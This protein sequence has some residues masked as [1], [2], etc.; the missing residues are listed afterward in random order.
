MPGPEKLIQ[1]IKSLGLN[2]DLKEVSR[3]YEFAAKAH[4]GQKRM[5]GEDFIIHPL[6]TAVNLAEMKVDQASILAG[7]L[8]D[9]VEDTP[10]SVKE[11]EKHF[12]H[13]VAFLVDSV[14][15]LKKVRYY[16]S[17]NYLE[18]LRKMFVAMAKDIRVILIKFAD[19]LHNLQTL[20]YLPKDEQQRIAKETL[21]I[22]APIANR[23]RL[24]RI[25]GRLEDWAFRYANPEDFRW[26]NNLSMK[27]YSQREGN[28]K[29]TETEI[30]KI[31]EKE[32]IR[33]VSIHDRTKFLYS[34]FKKMEAKQVAV[35]KIY[36]LVA[37]RIIVS[38]VP[39]CY[40]ALGIIHQKYK[41]LKGRIKDYIAQP[42]PNGYQSLH[43]TV[44]GENGDILEV[45]IR[46]P[47]IHEEAEYGIAAHWHY[48]DVG[49]K[50]YWDKR[51]SWVK[52][53]AHLM[54]RLEDSK[55]LE[56]LKI[57]FFQRRIFVFTP[58]GDVIDLPDNATPVDFAYHI[59][60][61]IGNKT[62][63]A[64]VNDHLVSLD[65]KLQNGDVV[66][67]ITNKKQ[68]G[69]NANWLKF[70]RTSMARS[71]IKEYH[72]EKMTK[73]EKGITSPSA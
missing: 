5:S 13:E 59:H 22:Y 69:P 49:I 32:K 48:K 21:E 44:F 60:T 53:L 52:E 7:L 51:L 4:A 55:D 16:G 29:K 18:N 65:T 43:T 17:P 41:P 23:L 35:D 8:H 28:L 63:R 9:V 57:D 34:L 62:T 58:N 45:Q 10:T 64:K 11:I 14:S 24:G 19:R 50:E 2:V 1:H 15:K 56:S 30:A 54:K 26:L 39:D 37:L 42:K 31:L 72:K 40:A 73:W 46:T 27:L 36:D 47:Q 66:E 38:S 70:V 12:G 25:R 33:V 6:E 68:A 67:V 3:A 71:R 20:E 61:E